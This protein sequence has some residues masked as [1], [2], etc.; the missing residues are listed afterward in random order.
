MCDLLGVPRLVVYLCCNKIRWVLST[1]ACPCYLALMFMPMHLC[2]S[3]WCACP[4]ISHVIFTLC[5]TAAQLIYGT[6]VW[7][8]KSSMVYN[9]KVSIE[10]MAVDFETDCKVVFVE[11]WSLLRPLLERPSC[12]EGPL[13]NFYPPSDYKVSKHHRGEGS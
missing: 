13:S 2:M 8:T 3:V 12:L 9:V 5:S 4:G 7:F 6:L 11:G 10:V 1:S